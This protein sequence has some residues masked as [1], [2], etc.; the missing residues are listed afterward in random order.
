MTLKHPTNASDIF[1]SDG[2]ELDFVIA[3]DKA[4]F[5]T[6]FNAVPPAKPG[7]DDELAFTCDK[8]YFH[9]K[10]SYYDKGILLL[11]KV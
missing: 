6:G 1:L 2:L 10:T 5:G 3:F 4:H 8:G 11:T 7:W 9:A